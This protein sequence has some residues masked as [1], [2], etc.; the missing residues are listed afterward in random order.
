MS[1]LMDCQKLS[2]EACAHAAQNDRLPVQTVV[3]V[4]YYEQLRMR[5]SMNENSGGDSN[6]SANAMIPPKTLSLYPTNTPSSD[7]L[8]SLRRENEGLKL[9][10]LKLKMKLKEVEKPVNM[11]ENSTFGSDTSSPAKSMTSTANDNANAAK[12]K[13]PLPRK[14]FM[15]SVKKLGRLLIPADGVLTPPRRGKASKGRRHSIS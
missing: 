10:L 12:Q 5:E 11:V 9:E 13:P 7:E 3:Q 1:S 8:L 6:S 15:N 2:P 14:S 4:L